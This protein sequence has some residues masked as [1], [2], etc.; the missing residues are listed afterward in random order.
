MEYACVNLIV[1]NEAKCKVLH[2]GQGNPKHKYR[3]GDEGIESRLE[4]QHLRLLVDK[5]LNTTWQCALTA[6]TANWILGCIKSSMASR[7][8]EG[9]LPLYSALV[10]PHLESC[11][12]LWSLQHKKDMDLP[13]PFQTRATKMIRGLKPHSDEE[14]LRDLRLF[15]L[16]KRRLQGDLIAAFQYLKAAYK[17]AGEGLLTRVWCDRTRSNSF[18]WRESRF[19]L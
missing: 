6:Q 10:R 18:K 14:R 8:K 12:Q 11:I 9:I 1:L 15:S 3:L 13:K 5:K 17:R 4:E 19:R 2:L 7:S 16:E